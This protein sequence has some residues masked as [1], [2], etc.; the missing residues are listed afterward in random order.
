MAVI[1]G[2]PAITGRAAVRHDVVM[3]VI[4]CAA[5]LG[6]Y[7]HAKDRCRRVLAGSR[8]RGLR[9][10][11]GPHVPSMTDPRRGVRKVAGH[12]RNGG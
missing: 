7:V 3:P 8:L 9:V 1:A 12:G 2:P 5:P 11:R 6:V 10:V 4:V